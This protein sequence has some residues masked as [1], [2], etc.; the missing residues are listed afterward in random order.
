MRSHELPSANLAS[1]GVGKKTPTKEP[2]PW[3]PLLG[4]LE[5]HIQG[6]DL[7]QQPHLVVDLLGYQ[8]RQSPLQ[9][10]A[11]RSPIGHRASHSL[12]PEGLRGHT[13]H[14]GQSF[15]PWPPLPPAI[16]VTFR[17]N[18]WPNGGTEEGEERAR[19]HH[20]IPCN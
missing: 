4:L 19:E 9:A 16:I 17:P 1:L 18:S 3:F 8:R 11:K 13:A 12:K 5:G 10:P 6:P 2:Q 14:S 7:C 15:S 20:S